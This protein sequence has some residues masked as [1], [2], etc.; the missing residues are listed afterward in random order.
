MIIS[1]LKLSGNYNTVLIQ[2]ICYLIISYLKLSGNYNY[3]GGYS[4]TNSIISYLK[5]SGN[6]NPLTVGSGINC[7]ISYLPTASYVVG[8]GVNSGIY[9]DFRDDDL[10]EYSAILDGRTTA[11]CS[12]LHKK[13][14]AWKE[15]KAQP[16]MIPPRHFGCRATLVRV[17]GGG[18]TDNNPAD[19]KKVADKDYFQNTTKKE[20]ISSGKISKDETKK[21]AS[22]RIKNDEF[23]LPDKTRITLKIALR[24]TNPNYL[25]AKEYQNDCQRCVLTYEMRRRGYDVETLPNIKGSAPLGRES[26]IMKMWGVEKMIFS[27]ITLS[28]GLTA[29]KLLKRRIGKY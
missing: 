2:L 20:L 17:V 29:E 22:A 1:Y 24:G 7:I 3:R 15:W 12:Y 14:M 27:E 5:L 13:R 26:E 10:I 25:T 8:K 6:Y 16:D 4:G 9:I 28:L 23:V 18:D 11:G 21:A 19:P